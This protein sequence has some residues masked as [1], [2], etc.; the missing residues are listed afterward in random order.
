MSLASFFLF[1]D[2]SFFA[3]M[4]QKRKVFAA[5]KQSLNKSSVFSRTIFCFNEAKAGFFFF[6][7]AKVGF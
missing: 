4:M 1:L 7:E 2:E 5:T 3:S 6:N